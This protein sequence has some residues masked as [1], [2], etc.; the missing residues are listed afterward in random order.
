MSSVTN[1]YLYIF[2]VSNLLAPVLHNSD[3]RM[4][5]MQ[6]VR[7]D[8]SS[9]YIFDNRHCLYPGINLKVNIII[10]SK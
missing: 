8:L 5:P 9:K 10:S 6:E 1:C 7:D 4:E 3:E 2:H